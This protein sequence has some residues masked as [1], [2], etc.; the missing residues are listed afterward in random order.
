M[1]DSRASVATVQ[2]VPFWGPSGPHD[3]LRSVTHRRQ[4]LPMLLVWS[5]ARGNS[6]RTSK[7]VREPLPAANPWQ[8]T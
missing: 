5:S 3:I 4:D 7:L 1:P 8:N 2:G 6:S